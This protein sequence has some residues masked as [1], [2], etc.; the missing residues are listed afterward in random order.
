M[1]T[2][3]MANGCRPGWLID[4]FNQTTYI[5]RADESIQIIR[6]FDQPPS[7]EDVLPGSAFGLSELRV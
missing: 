1:L 2:D 4:P 5:Y 3:W 7:S 6:G